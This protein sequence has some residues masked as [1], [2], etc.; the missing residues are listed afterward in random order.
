MNKYPTLSNDFT[1]KEESDKIKSN[2]S[3]PTL[4][5]QMPKL[6]VNSRKT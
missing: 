2:N 5:N 1:R 6:V 4:S 3:H